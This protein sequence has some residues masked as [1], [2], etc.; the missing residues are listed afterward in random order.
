MK[1]KLIK[2]LSHWSHFIDEKI[3]TKYECILFHMTD[4]P[5]EERGPCKTLN[6]VKKLKY[7]QLESIM[8]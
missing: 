4:L 6:L 5:L 1:W 8:E 7:Q 3:F 2:Y